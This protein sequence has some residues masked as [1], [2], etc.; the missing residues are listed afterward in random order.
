MDSSELADSLGVLLPSPQEWTVLGDHTVGRRHVDPLEG[1]QD[2]IA[3]AEG[4][5]KVLPAAIFF[6]GH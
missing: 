5:L 1:A 4:L 2:R 3:S 6:I